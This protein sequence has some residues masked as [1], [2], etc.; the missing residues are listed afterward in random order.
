M[1]AGDFY[2]HV[3]P[4]LNSVMQHPELSATERF[5]AFMKENEY[6]SND[7]AWIAY[8]SNHMNPHYGVATFIKTLV[9]KKLNITLPVKALI[10][11]SV[12]ESDPSLYISDE[13][14]LFVEISNKTSPIGLHNQADEL[15]AQ[16]SEAVD[17]AISKAGY[18][19]WADFIAQTQPKRVSRSQRSLKKSFA[20]ATGTTSPKAVAKHLDLFN[21]FLKCRNLHKFHQKQKLYRI[22]YV[23]LQEAISSG[24]AK[25]TSL[26][27]RPNPYMLDCGD[28]TYWDDVIAKLENRFKKGQ[29][30][31]SMSNLFASL[32]V[33]GVIAID[34]ERVITPTSDFDAYRTALILALI[35]SSKDTLA[36]ALYDLYESSR[37]VLEC[38]NTKALKAKQC[39][40]KNARNMFDR[41]FD[42]TYMD[43]WEID[44]CGYVF[45]LPAPIAKIDPSSAPKINYKSADTKFAGSLTAEEQKQYNFDD[46]ARELYVGGW[47]DRALNLKK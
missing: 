47:I 27:K 22:N 40:P 42:E 6:S 31:E 20:H 35:K 44:F 33:S 43:V 5:E 45:H 7:I 24:A 16:V 30:T 28:I 19:D 34:D 3:A 8:S 32:A 29:H 11:E 36:L 39:S 12:L 18:K 2:R 4:S 15:C 26:I 41:H 46:V 1:V 25:I 9:R 21:R 23:Y 38:F 13:G 17:A 10:S 37:D 14:K